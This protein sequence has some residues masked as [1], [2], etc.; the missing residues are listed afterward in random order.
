MP[1]SARYEPVLR[2]YDVDEG[3]LSLMADIVSQRVLCFDP[4]KTDQ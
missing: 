2:V 3:F 1:G 4:S